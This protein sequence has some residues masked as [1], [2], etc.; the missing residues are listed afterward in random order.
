M[1][2]GQQNQ[3]ISC[4][5]CNM[6]Q[7]QNPAVTMRNWL[8]TWTEQSVAAVGCFSSN[9]VSFSSRV[10]RLLT[11]SLWPEPFPVFFI[12][13]YLSIVTTATRFVLYNVCSRMLG[14]VFFKKSHG[15]ARK[16]HIRNININLLHLPVFAK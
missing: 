5:Y 11:F 9:Y 3:R 12:I 13:K 1:I 8:V 16:C 6:R 15:Q 14:P 2:S 10:L 7:Y 4:R